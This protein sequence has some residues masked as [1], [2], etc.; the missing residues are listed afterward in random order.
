MRRRS[1]L[2][3]LGRQPV[4]DAADQRDV[5][6]ALRTAETSSITQSGEQHVERMIGGGG[7]QQRL[8][9]RRA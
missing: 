3:D 9:R 4:L 1:V 8:R 2:V 6:A 5:I 7:S